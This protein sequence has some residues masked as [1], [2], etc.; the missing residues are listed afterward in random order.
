MN[1]LVR[2]EGLRV[3]LEKYNEGVVE[4]GNKGLAEANFDMRQSLVE[5]RNEAIDTMFYTTDAIL[6][7]D[8]DSLEHPRRR[9]RRKQNDRS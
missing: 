1:D 3:A 9:L 4:H 6:K 5:I 2:D 8:E 7:L